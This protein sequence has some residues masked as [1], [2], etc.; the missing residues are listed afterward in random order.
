MASNYPVGVDVD[1]PAQQNRVSVFFR[2]LFMI[3]AAIVAGVIVLVAYVV[4]LIGWF[5]I[6]F[7]GKFPEG[8][9]NFVVGALRWWT[10]VYG[11]VYLLTDKYPPFSLEDDSAYPV[12]FRGQGQ[13]EGRNRLT[14]F[15]RIILAIPHI[16]IIQVLGYAAAVVGLI[17]WFAA[18]F[19]GS[20]PE[21]MH[22]FLAGYIR[23]TARTYAYMFLVTDEYPP[24]SL[25]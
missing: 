25:S 6:L 17:S 15:F 22:N 21:G 9:V 16:I 13:S 24:F 4:A 19:T 8:M 3:P 23:W 11:Y 7:T 18:L 10:R 1:P 14:A 12:R 2:L 5:T 20:V